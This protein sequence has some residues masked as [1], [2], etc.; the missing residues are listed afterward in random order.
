MDNH[1]D[2][3]ER[4]VQ[5]EIAAKGPRGNP[6]CRQRKTGRWDYG[7]RKPPDPAKGSYGTAGSIAYGPV[8]SAGAFSIVRTVSI[9]QA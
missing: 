2:A 3:G 1:D 5:P 4:A 7:I 9:Q 6:G 8:I